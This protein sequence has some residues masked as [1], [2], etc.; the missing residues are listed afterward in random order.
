MENEQVQTWGYQR[1]KSSGDIVSKLFPG[2]KLP[3]GWV[4]SPAKVKT[5]GNASS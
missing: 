2:S 3:K 5:N 4:D 1:D